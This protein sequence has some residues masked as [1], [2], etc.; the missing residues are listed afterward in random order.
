MPKDTDENKEIRLFELEISLKEA[1]LVPLEVMEQ[2]VLVMELADIVAQKGS[3]HAVSD[4]GCAASIARSSVYSA[5]L[6][7]LI[8]LSQMNDQSF[9][10][11]VSNAPRSH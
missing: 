8:N 1:T 6:N 4:A 9:L 10:K 2:S 3:K 11:E 7:V 5:Y